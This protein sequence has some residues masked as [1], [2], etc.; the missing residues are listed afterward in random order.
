MQGCS[1]TTLSEFTSWGAAQPHKLP[2]GLRQPW[3]HRLSGVQRL[4]P[5]ASAV[6]RTLAAR[7]PNCLNTHSL[8]PWSLSMDSSEYPDWE[9]LRSLG[10]QTY[11]LFLHNQFSLYGHQVGEMYNL[12]G[13]VLTPVS[14]GALQGPTQN[15]SNNHCHYP[16]CD[17]HS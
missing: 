8:S 10:H 15:N 2:A 13:R 16:A 14:Q 4:A 5:C 7:D 9:R 6:R 1:F 3:R 12:L 11:L 17:N